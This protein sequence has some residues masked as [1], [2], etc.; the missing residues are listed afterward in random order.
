MR[1]TK[2]IKDSIDVA[3]IQADFDRLAL[4]S[5]EEW[6][7]NS[8]YHRFILKQVPPYSRSALEIG[9][10]TGAFVRLLARRVE[11]VLALSLIHI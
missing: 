2:A 5:R 4:L 3:R 11:H 9:C 1:Q 10:G 7:H 8:H 6:D